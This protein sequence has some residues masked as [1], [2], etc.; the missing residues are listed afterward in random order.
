MEEISAEPPKSSREFFFNWK[1]P[2]HLLS[3]F[4]VLII[5][6]AI[7][8]TIIAS[9]QS[10]QASKSV[11]AATPR[12]PI[13]QP[14]KSSSIWNLPIG[15]N[16]QYVAAG[17]GTSEGGKQIIMTSDANI[18]LLDANQPKRDLYFNNGGWDGSQNQRCN[19][20]ELQSWKVPVPDNYVVPIS[21]ENN[22]AAVLVDNNGTI[23]QFQPLSRCQAGGPV[24]GLVEY[25]QDNIN[26]GDGLKAGA[27]GGSGMSSIGGTV[28]LGELVP[29]KT[30]IP[31]ALELNVNADVW[32]SPSSG[33][34]RWPAN[35]ADSCAPGCYGGSNSAVRMGALLAIHPSVNCDSFGLNTEP[36]KIV[37]RTLQNYG[38][39]LV[40]S[41]AWE[42]YAIITESGPQGEMINEFKSRWGFD[43]DAR[44]SNHG[45]WQNDM[46]KLMSSLQVINNWSSSLYS[47]VSASNGS[48]GSGGGAPRTCWAVETNGTDYCGGGSNPP[49]APGDTQAPSVSVT[50]PINGATVS[51]AN[52]TLSANASDNVGVSRVEF[53]IGS[54]KVGEDTSSPY[55]IVWNSTTVA[56]GNYTVSAKAFDAANNQGTSANVSATVSNSSTPPPPTSSLPSPWV[57]A[58][59]G[60]VGQAGSASYSNNSFTVGGSG[61]DIWGTAD[62]FRYVYQDLNGDGTIIARVASQTNTDPWAKAGVMIRENTNG[63]SKHASMFVSAAN[64]LAF[65]RRTTTSGSSEHTSGS[66]GTAPVWV[67]LQRSG[68]TI[69]A[70]RSSDGNSWTTVGSTSISMS[71]G[72]KVGLAV[73]SHNNSNTSTAVFSNVSVSQTAPP[74]GFSGVYFDGLDFSGTQ[75]SRADSVL[76]FN[77]GSGAPFTGMGGDTFSARWT[78]TFNFSAG[79]YRFNATSDDGV[80]VFLDGTKILDGWKD[81]AA[82]TYNVLRDVTTGNHTVVVEYYENVNTASIKM[83]WVKAGTCHDMTGDGLVNVED[84]R[85]ILDHFGENA[86]NSP[87]SV[88]GGQS[89]DLSDALTVISKD[90]TTCS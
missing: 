9:L 87:Y 42:A 85:V 10:E 82:T 34:W 12:D 23:R 67:R 72:V 43:F 48:Q 18:L 50:A 16:A 61:S 77:W 90:K 89:I 68:N 47:T 45:P 2:T 21:T 74:A 14:F 28:R 26:T 88:A 64:G 7:P 71:A 55:S 37:C 70:S 39:Y 51:G 1:H 15:A 66:S 86:T 20:D 35:K 11:Q 81:Q 25:Q 60:A 44:D 59:I 17:I 8:L 52:A 49:P 63:S 57:T 36:A 75:F 24:Y 62:A 19:R 27:H 29:G 53:Y 78:G 84:V 69:T 46:R 33:G 80:R 6:I 76:N 54:T 32:V 30:I 5:L 3:L 58:N 65:Q 31:H 73:T 13:K 4:A 22:P 83:N 56:N 40:D 38:G 41:T 79:K